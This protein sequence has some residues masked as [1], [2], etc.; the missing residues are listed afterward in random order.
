VAVKKNR[1]N[2][3]ITSNF[4]DNYM[5]L[6]DISI[7]A[8]YKDLWH[9]EV[10]NIRIFTPNVVACEDVDTTF[11]MNFDVKFSDRLT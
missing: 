7:A 1:Q 9:C 5:R 3:L 4:I 10:K 8:V 11:Q 6:F 2:Q